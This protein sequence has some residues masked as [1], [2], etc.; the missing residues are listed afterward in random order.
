MLGMKKKDEEFAV[1]Y[2]EKNAY[3]KIAKNLKKTLPGNKEITFL[4]IGT[5]RVLIDI[6][7]PLVGTLLKESGI[8]NV[9]GVIGQ[10]VHAVN[11]SGVVC[12]IPQDHFIVA[13]DAMAGKAENLGK[14]KI[15]KGKCYPGSGVNKKLVSIGDL[16]ISLNVAVEYRGK[17]HLSA[18]PQLIWC[19][20]KLI[21]DV[22][23]RTIHGA[24][25]YRPFFNRPVTISQQLIPQGYWQVLF[26]QVH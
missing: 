14:L 16:S 10:P 17:L 24:G 18:S 25:E 7:G 15:R 1:D 9:L 21:A 23:V 26:K 8:K 19:G 20:A 2:R 6:F 11:L 12:K 3:I 13:V 4:C 22:I 5:D